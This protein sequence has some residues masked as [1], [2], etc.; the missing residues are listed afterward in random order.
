MTLHWGAEFIRS[1]LPDDLAARFHE[2][3]ADPSLKPGAVTAL[4]IYNG[5]TGDLIMEMAGD[6]PCRVSRS[7]MRNLFSEGLDVHY[8]KEVSAAYVIDD[9]TSP[10][11]GR[12]RVDFVDG[13]HAVG[14]IVVGADGAKSQ[15][16]ESILGAE[17]AQLT[18]A[19]VSLFNFPHKFSADL[20][21]KIRKHNDLFMT[22]IHPDHG[23]MFWLSS[24]PT[25]IPSIPVPPT[26][27]LAQSWTSPTPQPPKHGPS[28][29]SKAGSTRRSLRPPTSRRPRAAWRSS[30]PAQQ[31]TPSHGALPA[32]QSQR[33]RSS[34]STTARTGTA[35]RSGI[36]ARAE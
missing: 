17:A 6:N 25:P 22:S 2:A 34:R 5:K 19:P 4:P 35:R 13:G 30:R 32:P 20:A 33:T 27:T 8:G 1:C 23:T 10:D 7:K 9:S 21:L 18:S 11:H 24:A 36:I 12:V 16:R 3:Y 15:L 29:S 26:N 31:S 14:D 28:S